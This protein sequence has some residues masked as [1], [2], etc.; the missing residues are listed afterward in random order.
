MSQQHN[1]PEMTI[2]SEPGDLPRPKTAS[3]TLIAITL[4]VTSLVVWASWA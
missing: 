1:P 2:D 4:T 3:L